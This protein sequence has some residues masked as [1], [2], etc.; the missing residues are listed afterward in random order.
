MK[1]GISKWLGRAVLGL[2][3]AAMAAGVQARTLTINSDTSDPAPKKAIQEAIDRFEKENPEIEVELNVY[4]HESYKTAIRNWLATSPPDVVFWYVGNRMNVFVDRGLFEDVSDLWAENNLN[5]RMSKSA[6]SSVTRNGKQW[7]LPY[8]YYQWGIYYRKD[9]FE[10]HGIAVPET[11]EEYKAACATLKENGVTP[12]AIGNKN[13]WT[14]AGWFD[15]LNLRINGYDFHMQLM[16]GEV[17]YTDDRVRK[18][19]DYWKELV[20]PGYFLK[21]QASYSWQE[22]LP[23]LFKGEAAMYLIGNFATPFFPE[24]VRENMGFFKFPIIDK[25]VG[26]Y[27]DAPMDSL[28][29]PSRAE[30]KADAKKFLAFMA[31]PEQQELMNRY[32]K[33]LPPL[34]EAKLLDDRFIQQGAELLNAADGTAQFYDRDTEPAMAKAGMNGFQEFMLHPDRLDAILERLEKTRQRTFR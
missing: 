8:T 28:H 11:W 31:E 2:S 12:I 16:A 24:G 30:N 21:E 22:A 10:K 4:D 5:E 1:Y 32:L 23:A 6:V 34:K 20:E 17:P 9:I 33:Q 3:L 26:L 19:F 13:L 15:Y 25:S 18:V 27:E 29:I 7:G 14:T